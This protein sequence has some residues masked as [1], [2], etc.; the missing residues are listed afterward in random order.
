MQEVLTVSDVKN[1]L[2]IGHTK[3]YE[4][5]SSGEINSFHIGRSRRVRKL[6]LD[7]FVSRQ[8]AEEGFS[9]RGDA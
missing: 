4:L 6:D 7:D 8:L 9:H 1:E 3:V 5:L 2:R